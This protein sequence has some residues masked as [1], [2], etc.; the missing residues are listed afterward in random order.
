MEADAFTC[1]PTSR[2]AKISV[3]RVLF[4]PRHCTVHGRGTF[5]GVVKLDPKLLKLRQ[6]CLGELKQ[7]VCR[8]AAPPYH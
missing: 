1:A 7:R 4:L 8:A 6:S 2:Q 5:S 3:Y